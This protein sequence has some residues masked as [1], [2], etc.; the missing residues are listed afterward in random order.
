[1]SASLPPG[2]TPEHFDWKS[3]RQLPRMALCCSLVI[4]ACALPA[5]PAIASAAI[6]G[7][8]ALP[9]RILVCLMIP[10]FDVYYYPQLARQIAMVTIIPILSSV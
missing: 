5:K 4:C 8:S 3:E 2:V 6:N 9:K 7:K 1:L 10:P